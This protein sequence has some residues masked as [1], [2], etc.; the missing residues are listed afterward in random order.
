MSAQ[1]DWIGLGLQPRPNIKKGDKVVG[2]IVG[3]TRLSRARP[4]LA[5]PRWLG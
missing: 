3:P 4:V 2:L 5:Q 1:A